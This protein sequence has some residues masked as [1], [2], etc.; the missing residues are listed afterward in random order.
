[1]ELIRS[2][3]PVLPADFHSSGHSLLLSKDDSRYLTRGS[4]VMSSAMARHR[5]AVVFATGPLHAIRSLG[6]EHR[7]ADGSLD[8]KA[9]RQR[10]SPSCRFGR[11]CAKC[12]EIEQR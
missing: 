12:A 5:A 3:S 10:A 11:F 9:M 7:R 8:P 1:S 2:V 4:V 6:R